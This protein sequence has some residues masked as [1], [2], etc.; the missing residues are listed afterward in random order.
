[1]RV[2]NANEPMARVHEQT[3]LSEVG[4]LRRHGVPEPIEDVAPDLCIGSAQVEL[5]PGQRIG[6]FVVQRQLGR[7]GMGV[8]YEAIDRKVGRRLAL[9][10]VHR[11]GSRNLGTATDRLLREAQAL[12]RLNHPNIVS[13]YDFGTTDTGVYI[14]MEYL[15]GENLRKWLK[16]EHAWCEILDV[17]LEAGRGLSAAHAAGIVHR[18]FKPNNVLVGHDERVKV[19]D[20]GLARRRSAE[21]WDT[22]SGTPPE[23]RRSDSTPEHPLLGTRLTSM[24][25]I[26]GTTPYMSPEQLMDMDV[27]PASDQFSFCVALWEALYGERPYAGDSMLD[28]ALAYRDERIRSPRRNRVPKTVHRALLRG[29][30]IQPAD[31]FPSMDQLLSSLQQGRDQRRLRRGDVAL[32]LA[33]ASVT[34]AATLWTQWLWERGTHARTPVT[35]SSNR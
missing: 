25:V 10:L 31:R 21:S 4:S 2:A 1:M 12:A 18:D 5:S 35:D 26:I 13:L 11:R 33:T 28:L 34:L 30:Q 9:K 27:G 16:S 20:F 22:S 6:R 17:F 8:V 24:G 19:L 29:L 3:T 7:G 23:R 14:A 15:R 32:V